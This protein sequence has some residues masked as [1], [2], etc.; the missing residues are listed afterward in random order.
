M[1]Q[2]SSVMVMRAKRADKSGLFEKVSIWFDVVEL[3]ELLTRDSA[4]AVRGMQAANLK[5][6]ISY[7]R[8]AKMEIWNCHI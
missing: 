8:V 4:R 2:L 7:P 5:L 1:A 6:N 3:S